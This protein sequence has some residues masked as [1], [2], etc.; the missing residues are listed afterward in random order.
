MSE[1]TCCVCGSA[2]RSQE[3]PWCFRCPQ[4]GTWAST[5]SVGIN[6]ESL[7]VALD[8]CMR[9]KGL[10]E[11]RR[12]NLATVASRLITLGLNSHG[13]VLDVGSAHGWFLQV[14]NEKGLEAE[15][16]EPDVAVAALAGNG[17]VRVGY[18]PDALGADEKFDAI[19]FNDVLEHVPDVDAAIAACVRHLRSGGLLS[20][21]I[22]NSGGLFFQLARWCARVGLR[23]A[24][25]R[26]WQVGLP[27][28]HLWYFDK[29][30]LTRLCQ[31]HG[32]A[33]VESST[34][35]SVR[36]R[37]LWDR[38]HSDRRP[39]LSSVAGVVGVWLLAPVLNAP[40]ASDIMHL[41]FRAPPTDALDDP[42][43][44]A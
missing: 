17:R 28:P 9:E 14:A 39:S 12:D 18:F 10:A 34:L 38:A 24:F 8:E 35:D 2:M 21:N 16:I 20:I 15:G 22:P 27:S 5:L 41:I 29:S 3:A 7:H 37:G 11:L 25:E 33:L 32:F 1:I 6:Q 44:R 40:S 43:G 19:T 26:L 31:R 4:C 23:S 13:K 30:G 36:R 42:P